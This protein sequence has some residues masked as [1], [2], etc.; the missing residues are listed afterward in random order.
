MKEKLNRLKQVLGEIHDLD[1]ALAVLEW[2]HQVYMPQAG[3]EGRAHQC[4]TIS[5]LAH[6]K[7]VSDEIGELLE[8]LTE[9]QE[10]LPP[11]SDDYCLIKATKR[12]YER[13]TKVPASFVAEFSK[14]TSIA[15]HEWEKA[16]AK[17]D[18]SIF[19]PHL[20]KIFELRRQYS[21]FFAPYDHIYD[22][23]LDEFE[24]GLKT[25][26]VIAIFE[27]LRPLQVE[28]IQRIAEKEQ[29]DDSFLHQNFDCDRQWDFGVAASK[30]I[31]YDWSRGRQDKAAHPFTTT[32]SLNDVRITTRVFPDYLP[33][34]LFST[35]HESGHAIYEQNVSPSLDRTPLGTGASLAI[36]ESQSRMWENLVGSSREFWNFFYPQLQ[37]TFPQLSGVTADSFY[38]G[39]NK[40]Q[41][42]LIRVEADEAT[43]NL[44]IMLRLELEIAALEQRIAVKDMP[45][46]WNARMQE[47]LGI[48]PDNDANGILQDVHWAGGAIGYFPTYALGNLIS[49]QIW[50]CVAADIPDLPDRISRGDFK[51][52]RDWLVDKI[53]RHGAKFE[54]QE[55]VRQVTGSTISPEP[56]MRYLEKKYGEIY[57]L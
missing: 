2:D 39:I 50:E 46:M 44:H 28:L 26:D 49:A 24:P 1:T 57:A 21:G 17:S 12:D 23:L 9:Y 35:L 48:C 8:S 55:L 34:A 41:P 16:R 30:A 4:S 3:A 42:S 37:K 45:K 33:S 22:P 53:Y 20:E 51:S 36:H 27:E 15:H 47:Y 19:C 13:Q 29:P 18:F 11:D 32:F 54:P 43:Y 31:G 56:Y 25:R 7:F 38:R 52:L 6:E 14:V 10:T 5:R 40:V